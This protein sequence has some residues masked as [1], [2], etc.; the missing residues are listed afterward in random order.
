MTYDVLSYDPYKTVYEEMEEDNKKGYKDGDV[1]TSAYSG[2]RIRTYRCKY[3]KATD[4]LI[5]SEEEVTST[6]SRRDL[7][8]CKIKTE[9]ST[10]AT[11]ESTTEATT[12][13]PT[14]APT[15]AATESPTEETTASGET[16]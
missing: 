5:S 7:V 14:E 3:S 11:T 10:E 1:I 12:E 6:Y 4:E 15:E 9:D 13:P 2:Y 8:I 16:T